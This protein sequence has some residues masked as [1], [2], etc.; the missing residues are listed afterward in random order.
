M[1]DVMES[2]R[3]K[4]ESAKAPIDRIVGAAIRRRR[5]ERNLTP[6]ALSEAVG[7]QMDVLEDYE[8]GRVRVQAQHLRLIAKALQAATGDF[9]GPLL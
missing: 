4:T 9:F 7:I 1:C 5:L 2:F 6:S 8:S 3:T